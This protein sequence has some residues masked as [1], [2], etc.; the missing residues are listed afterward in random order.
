MLLHSKRALSKVHYSEGINH[1][2]A[3]QV[4]FEHKFPVEEIT[5]LLRNGEIHLRVRRH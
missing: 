2:T 4:E 5:K 1:F 3:E